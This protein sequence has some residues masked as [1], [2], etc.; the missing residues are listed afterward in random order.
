MVLDSDDRQRFKTGTQR[1]F[2]RFCVAVMFVVIVT[3]IIAPFYGFETIATAQAQDQEES[4]PGDLVFTGS[5]DNTIKAI[6][7]NNGTTKW[8]FSGHSNRI[9]S[10]K[11]GP[12]GQTLYSGSADLTV[13][14][15]D[16]SDGSQKWSNT[17]WSNNIVS[18]TVS[19]DG[20]TVY[21]A[22]NQGRIKEIDE[23][24]GSTGWS[25]QP[26]N[27]N[28]VELETTETGGLFGGVGTNLYEISTTDGSILQNV[29]ISAG[30]QEI[31]STSDGSSLYIGQMDGTVKRYTSDS[32]S[33]DWSISGYSNENSIALSPDESVLYVGDGNGN[34]DAIQVS[35][36]SYEWQTSPVSEITR[37]GI[38]PDG[39]Q[40]YGVTGS[41]A[42][43]Y[44]SS[45][46][47]SIWTNNDHSND[48][49]SLASG[50]RYSVPPPVFQVSGKV[51]NDKQDPIKSATV[52]IQ[53]QTDGSIIDTDNTD[54]TGRYNVSATNGTYDIVAELPG[55][56]N[57]TKQV[58]ID[59]SDKTVDFTLTRLDNQ[60][61]INTRPFLNH[62]QTDN[63][64]VSLENDT[65]RYDVTDSA[66]VTSNNTTV[67]AIDSQATEV[68]ATSDI[69]INQR[70]YVEATY[71]DSEG[72][73]LTATQNVTVANATVE[74]LEILPTWT[75]IT[76]S[77]G[78]GTG[79]VY[80][81]S[82]EDFTL[83]VILV[84][85]ILG[86]AVALVSRVFAGLATQA[87]VITI[88]WVAGWVGNGVLIV[89]FMM[90]M[91]IGLNIAGN[92]DYTV[93]R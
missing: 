35:D 31:D 13:R 47:S 89:G 3:S 41:S 71:T 28:T 34:L 25:I 61:S 72:R 93:R 21:A 55:Y 10:L 40:L 59:G 60:L 74:N 51:T 88:G 32:L 81:P 37:L 80:Q 90:A 91:F 33:V 11:V 24:S 53:N 92:I 42:Q 15:I 39:S 29:S 64:T 27:S 78:G 62:G 43:A 54:G 66:T 20:D 19:H 4:G 26:S 87:I 52:S 46:G 7:S 56:D 68:V 9:Q 38:S 58:T 2:K 49:I 18:V 57:I 82:G 5:Y 22:D 63:Y 45:D 44:E 73:Q 23:S 65:G 17:D 85:T 50:G 67:V 14:A 1:F 79:G 36:Q 69:S 83:R 75:R 16:I 6:Y 8:T 84:A 76:A 77:L 70:T 86:T 12:D 48:I 30:P